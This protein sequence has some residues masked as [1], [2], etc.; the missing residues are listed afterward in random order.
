MSKPI[1]HPNPIEGVMGEVF[2]A[3]S[4][5]H[6]VPEPIPVSQERL[7]EGGPIFL[8]ETDEWAKHSAEHLRAAIEAASR[9]RSWHDGLYSG[10]RRINKEH[11]ISDEAYD[12]LFDLFRTFPEPKEGN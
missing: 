7:D 8:T 1:P 2:S 3:L 5:L 9:I 11:P 10:L 6:M 4:S 12:A